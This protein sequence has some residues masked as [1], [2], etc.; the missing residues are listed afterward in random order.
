MA[1]HSDP[2][3]ASTQSLCGAGESRE[4]GCGRYNLLGNETA[5]ALALSLSIVF[6]L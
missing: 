3:P 1:Q 6:S 4:D 5:A 2:K